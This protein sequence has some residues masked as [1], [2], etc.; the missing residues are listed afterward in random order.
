MASFTKRALR[1]TILTLLSQLP[2]DQI[3]VKMIVDAC[4]ISRNT[5][6]YH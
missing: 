5:F 2:L 1:R 6:Y 3:T 4:G